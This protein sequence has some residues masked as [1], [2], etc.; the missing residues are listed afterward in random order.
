LIP[1][2][3]QLQKPV[4]LQTTEEAEF[5]WP[6]TLPKALDGDMSF[7]VLG[8]FPQEAKHLWAERK[9]V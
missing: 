5:Y 9:K 4:F 8:C 1:R 3:N 6:D 7:Q 2:G